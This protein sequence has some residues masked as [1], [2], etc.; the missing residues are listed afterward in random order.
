MANS[1]SAQTSTGPSAAFDATLDRAYFVTTDQAPGSTSQTTNIAA[2]K[3]STRGPLW[4]VR[5]PSQNPASN[6]TRWGSNGLA[7]TESGA[8]DSLV[9]LSG[10]VITQ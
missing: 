5:F 8:T 10:A 7:F 9:L 2:F 3:L 1:F 6:L 4:L